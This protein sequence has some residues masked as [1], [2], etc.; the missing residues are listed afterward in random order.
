MVCLDMKTIL[1]LRSVFNYSDVGWSYYTRI[2]IAILQEME[3]PGSNEYPYEGDKP[4]YDHVRMYETLM[5][6]RSIKA[7]D[8]YDPDQF[9]MHKR[10]TSI[11]LEKNLELLRNDDVIL[12]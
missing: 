10:A 6:D 4:E 3:W 5:I 1:I 11:V 2:P 9:E 12:F 7:L 8:R